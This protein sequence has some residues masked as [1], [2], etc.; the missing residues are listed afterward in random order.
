MNK[1]KFASIFETLQGEGVNCGQATTFI[2]LHTED[3]FPNKKVC[4]FCD[5]IG[6]KNYNK[7]LAI[8]DIENY[9]KEN[10]PHMITLTGG[11]PF[12]LDFES[13]QYLIN[14]CKKYCVK[15][16]VETNGA[17]LHLFTNI[18]QDF[19]ISSFDN[20]NISPKLKTSNVGWVYTWKYK[21]LK[22]KE[23]SNF[24]FVIS[25]KNFEEEIAEV[26]KWNDELLLNER[27]WLM[28]M[29][30]SKLEFEKKLFDKCI[31]LKYNYSTRLHITLFGNIEEEI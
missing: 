7:N 14:L 30:P 25:E 6:K 1:L 4:S 31:K 9:L 18:Q 29:T 5:T 24:K 12:S 3:C 21:F 26:N 22:F 20:I 17:Y 27:I 28:P 8:N 23:K 19:F 15:L 2:R 10:A 11:E 16:E 13:L